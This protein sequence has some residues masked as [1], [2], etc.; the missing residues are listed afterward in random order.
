[1]VHPQSKR[2]EHYRE[3]R[4]GNVEAAIAYAVAFQGAAWL[5]ASLHSLAYVGK[6]VCS[7]YQ[8][9]ALNEDMHL[10]PR[11]PLKRG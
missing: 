7:A 1:M 9:T 2:L 10:N 5:F 6:Q 11:K 4:K 8:P 3:L